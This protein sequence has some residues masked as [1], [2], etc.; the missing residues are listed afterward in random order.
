MIFN[1]FVI[2]ECEKFHLFYILVVVVVVV[3]YGLTQE[4]I[5]PSPPLPRREHA[6]THTHTHI[7]T[8]TTVIPQAVRGVWKFN[9]GL[10][11]PHTKAISRLHTVGSA[12]TT[13]F[14]C[15][16]P[17]IPLACVH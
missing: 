10:R 17:R 4:R 13:L 3:G 6:H 5:I 14:T 16:N 9:I 2:H 12:P 1:V 8:T 11:N 7:H 15:P